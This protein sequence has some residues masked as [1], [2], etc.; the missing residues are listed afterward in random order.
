LTSLP[1][2]SLLDGFG[3]AMAPPADVAPIPAKGFSRVRVSPRHPPG[4]YGAHE[5]ESAL[6]IVRAE[7]RLSP[8][9]DG[10]LQAYGNTHARA[11]EPYL[12]AAAMALLLLDALI[13]LLLRG[14]TPRKLRWASAAILT[15]V[16]FVPQA[17][18]QGTT[19]EKAALDTLSRL[20]EDRPGRCGFGQPGGTDRSELY[21]EGPYLLRAAGTSGRGSGSR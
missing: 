18:A 20:C 2:V 14:F 4:L 10:G 19:S 6:N 16:L 12:L 9:P 3:H 21:A 15:F 11:L 13:S 17:R 7:D 8:L 5:V 1:P